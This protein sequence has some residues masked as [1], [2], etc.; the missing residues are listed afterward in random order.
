MKDEGQRE[1]EK[2]ITERSIEKKKERKRIF[3]ATQ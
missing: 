1:E 2:K 3:N